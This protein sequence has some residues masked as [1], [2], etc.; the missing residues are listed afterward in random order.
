MC[1]RTRLI[2]RTSR[3]T[4]TGSYTG[5]TSRCSSASASTSTPSSSATNAIESSPRAS[6]PA[7]SVVWYPRVSSPFDRYDTC[8]AGP[9]VFRRAIT[10][11]MRMGSDKRLDGP[12]QAFLEADRRFPAEHLPGSGHVGPGVADVADARRLERLLDRLAEHGADRGG[13]LVHGRRCARCDVEDAAARAFRFRGADRRLDD[14]RDIRE[15]APLLAVAVDG[16]RLPGGDRRHEERDHRGVLRERA[17][18]RAEDV[19]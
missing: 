1:G 17:L 12:A 2:S 15:V 16:D 18:L 6:R 8:S 7:T 13:D 11:R 5:E 3:D 9:P 14:V 4:A 10:R 19:E